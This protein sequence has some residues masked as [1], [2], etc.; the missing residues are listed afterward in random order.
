MDR[1][2]RDI[3]RLENSVARYIYIK[4]I[5]DRVADPIVESVE[6]VVDS[7]VAKEESSDASSSSSDNEAIEEATKDIVEQPTIKVNTKAKVA[8]PKVL[9]KVSYT[10]YRKNIFHQSRKCFTLDQNAII[11]EDT[12]LMNIADAA[13]DKN[14]ETFKVSEYD[15]PPDVLRCSFI[16]KHHHRYYRCRNTI[17]NKDSDICKKH[18]THENIYYDNYNDLLDKIIT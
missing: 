6:A 2:S 18:E 10:I 16:R 17:M 3:N 5:Q 8:R 11:R 9:D 12:R 15:I 1:V 13:Y 14:P 4:Y 7:V